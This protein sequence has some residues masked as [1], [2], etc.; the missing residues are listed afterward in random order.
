MISVPYF[1]YHDDPINRCY[2]PRDT[3][4]QSDLLGCENVIRLVA[5]PHSAGERQRA[6]LVGSPQKVD[7]LEIVAALQRRGQLRLRP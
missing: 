7:R 5:Y 6:E 2:W 3:P 1:A 4:G